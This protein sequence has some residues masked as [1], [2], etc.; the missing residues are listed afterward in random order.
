MISGLSDMQ[1]LEVSLHRKEKVEQSENQQLFLDPSE[2]WGHK[3]YLCPRVGK[4]IQIE[5]ENH[6]LLEKKA[7]WN[8][9]QS[10][11]T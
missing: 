8:Q 3:V 11:R 7:L 2:N 1:S 5:T 9:W 10:Q 6:S 4:D